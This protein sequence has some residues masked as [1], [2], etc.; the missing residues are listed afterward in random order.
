MNNVGPRTVVLYHTMQKL[1]FIR[2]LVDQRTQAVPG[3]A[4]WETEL[5]HSANGIRKLFTTDF[6]FPNKP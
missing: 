1:L 3:V 4:A 6:S 5:R 2:G